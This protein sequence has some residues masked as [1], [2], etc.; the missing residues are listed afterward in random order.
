MQV[1]KRELRYLP[2]AWAFAARVIVSA[3]LAVDV[4]RIRDGQR[5]SAVA[6]APKK[7]LRMAD[8][9]LLHGPNQMPLDVVL[10]DNVCKS[11]I[12]QNGG[13]PKLVKTKKQL[14]FESAKCFSFCRLR[15]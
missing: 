2:A 6:L 3:V 1:G 7:H 9:V 15:R 10:P 14:K 5:E 13:L 11:H 12:F 8:A 4:L